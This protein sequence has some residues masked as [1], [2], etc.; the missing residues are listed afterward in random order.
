MDRLARAERARQIFDP[1]S[2]AA[3]GLVVVAAL[4]F[5]PRPGPRAAIL[6][7]AM[8]FTWATG[9]KVPVLGTG[10]VILGIVGA[11][12]LVPVGRVLA[13]WGPIR[14]TETALLEGVEKAVTFEALIYVSKAA[15]RSDLRIPGRPGALIGSALRC[16]ERI[17]ET[18]IR[19][20]RATFLRDLDDILLG[21]YDEELAKTPG[22]P[23]AARTGRGGAGT[24]FTVLAAAAAWVPYLIGALR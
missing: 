4:L 7:G 5:Q 24:V 17:L 3:A 20:R 22:R 21:I 14:V 15:I 10:L 12:L 16:Y 23:A 1:H 6:L 8:V 19:I 18:R 2:L 11:N 9:R 13:V